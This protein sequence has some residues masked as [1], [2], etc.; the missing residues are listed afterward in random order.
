LLCRHGGQLTA[1]GLRH[2][3]GF[4]SLL[5]GGLLP[6]QG[7]RS[8]AG[9]ALV[10]AVDGPHGLIMDKLTPKVFGFFYLFPRFLH[11]HNLRVKV[12]CHG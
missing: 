8:Q 10:V 9:S 3:L 6:A 7:V 11:E 2:L 12:V 5:P 4:G 1:A